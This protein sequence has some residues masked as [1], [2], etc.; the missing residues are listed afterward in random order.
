MFGTN[1]EVKKDAAEKVDYIIKVKAARTTKNDSIVM[2]DL[3]INGVTIKSCFLKEITVKKDGEKYKKGDKCY[4]VNFPSE[5]VGEKYYNICWAPLTNDNVD[6]II[7][8][9]KSLLE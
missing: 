3:D 1:K 8:Q 7:K 5:K 6:D 9:V 4:V 2:I